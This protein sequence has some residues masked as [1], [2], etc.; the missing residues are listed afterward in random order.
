MRS[1]RLGRE[2]WKNCARPGPA[3][4]GLI[5][6]FVAAESSA[7]D[8]SR[9]GK[10]GGKSPI[11]AVSL[12]DLRFGRLIAGGA[13]TVVIDPA[14][15]ARQTLGAFADGSAMFGPAR[16]RVTGA[17]NKEIIVY[18][19]QSFSLGSGTVVGSLTRDG[20]ARL[21][22][23]PDGSLLVQVGGTLTLAGSPAHGA[24]SAVFLIDVAYDDFDDDDD[25]DD[26]RDHPGAGK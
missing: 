14:T 13:A 17:P 1:R 24:L 2:F 3:V 19:P 22:L 7:A 6:L 18:L 8:F 20:P 25:D 4:L 9:D 10:G 5:A 15:G 11:Q 23:G 21:R 16:F 12:D 26:D